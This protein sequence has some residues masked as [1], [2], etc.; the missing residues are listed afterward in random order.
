MSFTGLSLF[1]SSPAGEGRCYSAPQLLHSVSFCLFQ[2]SPAGEGRCYEG[3]MSEDK[4]E[5]GFQSSP[6][7]EGRCYASLVLQG[8]VLHRVS[9]LTGR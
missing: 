8:Y 2:S 1:Q 4:Q 6:A 7:G 3:V 5:Y 9:I